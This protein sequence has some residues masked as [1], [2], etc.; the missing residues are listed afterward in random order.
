MELLHRKWIGANE[1][2]PSWRIL[3]IDEEGEW[4]WVCLPHGSS[5]GGVYSQPSYK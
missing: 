4:E 5:L 2:A 3:N 1:T